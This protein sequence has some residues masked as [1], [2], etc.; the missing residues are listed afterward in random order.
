MAFAGC[1]SIFDDQGRFNPSYDE[2]KSLTREADWVILAIGQAVDL[3]F[4]NGDGSFRM[5][6]GGILYAD[7]E[8]HETSIPG[9]FAGG[10]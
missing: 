4:L 9:T 5:G 10:D 2:S 7:K 3:T 6:D 8:T 1:T